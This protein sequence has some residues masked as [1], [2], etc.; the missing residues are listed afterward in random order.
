MHFCGTLLAASSP[1]RLALPVMLL[2]DQSG[3]GRADDFRFGAYGG[4]DPV[5]RYSAQ[6]NHG[7]G[8][9][10]G[11]KTWVKRGGWAGRPAAETEG[12]VVPPT[13]AASQWRR[14]PEQ[15]SRPQPPQLAPPKSSPAVAPQGAQRQVRAY[16]APDENEF[17]HG[18]GNVAD[19]RDICKTWRTGG[20]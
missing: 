4:S 19:Q 8:H 18:V 1:L 7:Q 5:G 14:E 13:P 15:W 2:R 12:R 17:R 11:A 6:A 20:P 3:A 9:N 16:N 10:A